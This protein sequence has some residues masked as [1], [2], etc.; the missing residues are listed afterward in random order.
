MSA[1]KT[2]L[3]VIS[4][5]SC[6]IILFSACIEREHYS[7]TLNDL[8]DEVD[9]HTDT[10]REY[11]NDENYENI[12]AYAYGMHEL[13]RPE[14]VRF[15]W[16]ATELTANAPD[17]AEYELQIST[18]EYF[19]EYLSYSTEETYYDVYNLRIATEYYWRVEATL[20]NG[21]SSLSSTSTFETVDVGPRNI[22]VDGVTNVRDIGGWE[23][24]DGGRVKQG[25]IYRCGRLNT[26]NADGIEVDE[27]IVEITEKGIETMREELGICSE[28]DMRRTDNNEV[29][30]LTY[31]PL[32]DDV[33][34]YSCPMTWA[35]SNLLLENIEIVKQTFEIL[36]DESNYP[37][38]YH[39]NIG[40][41]RTGLYSYLINGLMGVSEEDLYRDYLFSNFGKINGSR[42]LSGIKYSYIATIKSYDGDT[43][44]E[45]IY[46]CLVDRGVPSEH[47]DAVIEIL[48]EY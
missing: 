42:N 40:T 29:G 7:W 38:I 41:D 19:S 18:D 31:S 21:K 22:Y 27:V 11:L 6:G 39:C 14:A 10:Q 45:K 37:I 16:K 23:T 36:A 8:G 17:I 35:V 47:L 30:F 9:F 28:I 12:T 3:A 24:A 13:S 44:S 5:L 33:N 43:L 20:E 48:T 25:M 4:V 15:E 34:Y 46:N 26:S 1:K 2:L 32:G